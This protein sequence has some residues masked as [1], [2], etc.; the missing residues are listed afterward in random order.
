MSARFLG[1]PFVFLEEDKKVRYIRALLGP[2]PFCGV[3]S[4]RGTRS[5]D[6]LLRACSCEGGDR[7]NIPRVGSRDV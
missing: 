1:Q 4:G 2:M 5:C 3:K 7:I 6:P